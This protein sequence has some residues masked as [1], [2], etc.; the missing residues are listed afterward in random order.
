MIANSLELVAV[1]SSDWMEVKGWLSSSLV[2]A[3]GWAL[4]RAKASNRSN[5]KKGVVLMRDGLFRQG[6]KRN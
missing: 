1:F 6:E 3:N 4:A 2:E 5:G